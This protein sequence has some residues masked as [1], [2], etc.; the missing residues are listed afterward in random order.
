MAGVEWNCVKVYK[1]IP[2][3][4]KRDF[5]NIR[6]CI[7]KVYNAPVKNIGIEIK[8]PPMAHTRLTP[9]FSRYLLPLK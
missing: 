8:N 7:Q 5:N 9:D 3:K 4:Q 2:G 6:K 1:I